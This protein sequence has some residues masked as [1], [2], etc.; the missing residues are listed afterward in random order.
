MNDHTDKPPADSEQAAE[1]RVLSCITCEGPVPS[2]LQK[3]LACGTPLTGKEFVYVA[4]REA[5]PDV[6]GLLKWWAIWS[7]VVLALGGFSFGIGS[8]IAFTLV[9]MV[10]LFRILRAYFS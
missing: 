7:I 5:G 4:R 2:N 9:T 6:G 1:V 3:C 10:Y 8:S